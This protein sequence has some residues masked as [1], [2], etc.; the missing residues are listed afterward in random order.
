MNLEAGCLASD[1]Q[2]VLMM[3][4]TSAI[5]S[6]ALMFVMLPCYAQITDVMSTLKSF[7]ADTV[8]GRKKGTSKTGNSVEHST[9]FL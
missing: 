4:I 7:S 2:N 3:K 8:S 1:I 9:H 6:I 5:I